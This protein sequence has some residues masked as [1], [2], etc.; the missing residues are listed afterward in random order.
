M[1]FNGTHVQRNNIPGRKTRD[2]GD[3]TQLGLRIDVNA[4][5]KAPGKGAHVQGPEEGADVALSTGEAGEQEVP[6]V[7]RGEGAVVRGSVSVRT[8]HVGLESWV[9]K[10]HGDTG[11]DP[12]GGTSS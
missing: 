8:S 12:R 4:R 1:H 5:K 2:F 6:R 3:R 9:W 11:R 7:E 10:V